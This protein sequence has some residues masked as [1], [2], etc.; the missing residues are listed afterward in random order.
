MYSKFLS[1][2]YIFLLVYAPVLVMGQVRWAVES[3]VGYSDLEVPF[4]SRN[5]YELLK[6]NFLVEIGTSLSGSIEKDGMLGWQLKLMMQYDGFRSIPRDI[7]AIQ[8]DMDGWIIVHDNQDYPRDYN[9]IFEQRNW[10]LNVPV[11]LTFNAF[12]VVGLLAGADFHLTLNRFDKANQWKINSRGDLTPEFKYFNIGAHLGLFIPVNDRLRIDLR[13]F[14]DV[15]PRLGY[16]G[17]SGG[18]IRDYR[19]VGTALNVS[20]T[21]NEL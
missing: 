12:E 8:E 5:Y 14:S 19:R 10:S 15:K 2:G 6:G 3:G 20:Y 7:D 16:F 4:S 17:E 18:S 11:S 13:V 21:L 9:N 1:S